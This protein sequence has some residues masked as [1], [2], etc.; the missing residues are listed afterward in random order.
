MPSGPFCLH[1]E[2]LLNLDSSFDLLALYVLF[3]ARIWPACNSLQI[4]LQKTG[5]WATVLFLCPNGLCAAAFALCHLLCQTTSER[6]LRRPGV[7]LSSCHI[8]SKQA[9]TGCGGGRRSYRGPFPS[10]IRPWLA[11]CRHVRGPIS[12]RLP[13]SD[14]ARSLLDTGLQPFGP[15][16]K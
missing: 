11:R 10:R 2:I 8:R 14:R 9:L 15:F 3:M 16:R 5:I 12:T 1:G 13:R 4:F 6:A 7:R